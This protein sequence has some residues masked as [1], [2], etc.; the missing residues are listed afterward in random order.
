MGPLGKP[1]GAQ[2]RVT[3]GTSAAAVASARELIARKSYAKAVE[4]LR[5]ELQRRRGDE[6]LRVQL[7]E[8]L[9]LAGRNKEAADVLNA[10][11]DD[12]ALTGQ[13]GKAIAALKKIERLDPG[14]EDV[15]EKL[16]YFIARHQR[17]S[18]DPW[19]RAKGRPRADEA[20]AAPTPPVEFGME[21]IIEAPLPA[22]ET[23][24]DDSGGAATA[25][26]DAAIA[27]AAGSDA[28][29]GPADAIAPAGGGP[30]FA[31][32]AARQELL[33]VFEEVLSPVAGPAESPLGGAPPNVVESPLFQDFSREELLE[34]MRGLR[35]RS[36]EPGEIVVSAGEPGESLFLI[37][38]GSVRAYMRDK[39]GHHVQVRE[40]LEGDFF[41]EISILTGNPR[42]ATITAS[43]YCE[44]LEL[45]RP[46]LNDITGR[47]PRVRE[48]LQDFY[49]RRASHSIES[50]IP[51]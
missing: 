13:A 22:G 42:S 30:L 45:D 28:A 51:G 2:D 11:A 20:A 23:S 48:V 16:S 25:A 6:R 29:A 19:A 41:G 35:L 49:K 7:A 3:P 31:D 8:T 21:E 47:H 9:G 27:P 14:R 36:F 38:T 37:T 33:A 34:V 32:E 26:T 17:P 4:V 39:R 24:A 10:L 1:K 40:M 50:L 5:A 12:L 46:A 18:F 44:L 43:S 15:A